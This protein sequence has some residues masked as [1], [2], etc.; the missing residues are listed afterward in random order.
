MIILL[1]HCYEYIANSDKAVMIIHKTDYG[2]TEYD[3]IV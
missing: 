2:Y 1:S 3:S